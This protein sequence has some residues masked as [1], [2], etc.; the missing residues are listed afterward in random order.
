MTNRVTN[1]PLLL[2]DAG[3]LVGTQDHNDGEERFFVMEG[4]PTNSVAFDTTPDTTKSLLIGEA[5]WNVTDGTLDLKLDDNVTLQIGQEQN[6]KFRNNDSVDMVDGQAVYVTGSTGSRA[7]I[8][9]A[10]ASSESTSAV[11]IGLTTEPIAKNTEGYVTTFGLVRDLNTHDLT[12]GAAVW[13]SPTT[14]GGLTST[15][16]TAPNHLVLV[17]Y[18]VRSHPTLGAI[19]VKPQNGYEIGELHDVLISNPQ[20]G[21]VLKYNATAGYWYNANP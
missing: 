2:N 6:Q 3:E 20:D 16:P 1:V 21:Q 18:C 5:R 7:T 17:G 12:E 4:E 13:L 9:L 14:P 19:F 15:Q 11:I 10:Q 8:R